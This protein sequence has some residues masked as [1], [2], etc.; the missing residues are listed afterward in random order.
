M[1]DQARMATTNCLSET[2]GATMR[3]ENIDGPHFYEGY[4]VTP[5]TSILYAEGFHPQL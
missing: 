1:K 4:R 3:V 2:A 5:D